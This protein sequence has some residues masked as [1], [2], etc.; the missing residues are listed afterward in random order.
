MARQLEPEPLE[1]NQSLLY[2]TMVNTYPATMAALSLGGL[3]AEIWSLLSY[4]TYTSAIHRMPASLF[5]G[6]AEVKGLDMLTSEHQGLD[7]NPKKLS[8]TQY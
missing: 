2:H 8:P 5:D 4:L 7:F 1:G 6:L 3:E